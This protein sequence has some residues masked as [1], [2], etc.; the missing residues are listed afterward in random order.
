MTEWMEDLAQYCERNSPGRSATRLRAA[1]KVISAIDEYE[2]IP[3]VDFHTLDKLNELWAK[4][5][6]ALSELRELTDD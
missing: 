4:L 1:A 3:P 6:T 2:R 5:E